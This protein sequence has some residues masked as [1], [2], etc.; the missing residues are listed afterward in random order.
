LRNTEFASCKQ[1]AMSGDH[2]AVA[3]DQNRDNKAESLDTVGD[4]A[5]L[6]LGMAPRGSPGRAS[7]L[8]PADR[9][10]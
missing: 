9:R 4:L 3:I 10:C 1:P 6:L 8:Q 7:V 2:F 5:Y